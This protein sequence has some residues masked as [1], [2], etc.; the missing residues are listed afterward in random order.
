MLNGIFGANQSLQINNN[1][2]NK[3]ESS[4]FTGAD[5]RSAMANLAARSANLTVAGKGNIEEFCFNKWRETEDNLY[6]NPLKE[7]EDAAVE[8]LKKLKKLLKE[9]LDS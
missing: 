5:F 2:V 6:F 4:Q 3:T 1:K 8:Q 9:K 7:E